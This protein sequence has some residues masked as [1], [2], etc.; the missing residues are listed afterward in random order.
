MMD[1]KPNT[2]P[3]VVNVG[4]ERTMDNGGASKGR[5]VRQVTGEVGIPSE[6]EGSR[7]D[8]SLRSK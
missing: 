8:F 6:C 5:K 7:K 4:F 3:P 1:V 2:E